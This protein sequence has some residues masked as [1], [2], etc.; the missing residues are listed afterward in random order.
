MNKVCVLSFPTFSTCLGT[1]RGEVGGRLIVT[2]ALLLGYFVKA[3]IS[4][5]MNFFCCYLANQMLLSK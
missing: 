5:L 2:S 4:L 3:E 1:W